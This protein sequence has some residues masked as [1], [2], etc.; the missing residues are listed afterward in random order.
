MKERENM[1]IKWDFRFSESDITLWFL[2]I[3]ERKKLTSNKA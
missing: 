1:V 3:I 2:K